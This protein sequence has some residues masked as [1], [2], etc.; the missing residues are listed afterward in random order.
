MSRDIWDSAQ[1]Q[2]YTGHRSRPFFDLLQAVGA[3]HPASVVDLGCGPGNLTATLAERWPQAAVLGVDLSA[4]MLAA[5]QEHA[6][7]GRVEFVR[8]DLREW[9][10]EAPV[11]V[12]V[13]NAALQWVPDHRTLLARWVARLNPEGWFAFQVPGNLSAPSHAI[14]RE[15]CN[16][17][18]WRTQVGGILRPDWIATPEQ[19]LEDLIGL[20]CTADVW[21]TTYLQVLP[22]EDP[23]LDWVKGTALRPVLDALA[24]ADQESLLATYRARLREV[25]PRRSWGT[26][27]PFRRVFAVAQRR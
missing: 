13:S 5:A 25:Y 22:G 6:V 7:P 8:G 12:M 24:P 10:P 27:F 20:G 26:V 3:S 2:R 15:V 16:L 4:G 21:E 18:E 19:Y 11:D 17:P 14:L 1:Y 23:V 9:V